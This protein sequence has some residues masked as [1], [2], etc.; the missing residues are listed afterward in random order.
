MSGQFVGPGWNGQTPSM[1]VNYELN[2]Y[3]S[4]QGEQISPLGEHISALGEQISVLGEQILALGEQISAL[5]EQISA[6]GEQISAL[7]HK[8]NSI[9]Q[10]LQIAKE[11]AAKTESMN[12]VYHFVHSVQQI[13]CC[14]LNIDEPWSI[15]I[16]QALKL[17]M[18]NWPAVKTALK[19]ED[20]DSNGFQ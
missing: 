20:P 13:L 3:I 4:A 7:N 8:I 1:D 14:C 18:T 6:Q 15:T 2:L 10:E 12:A 9:K 16:T 11:K 17:G 19:R 5:G